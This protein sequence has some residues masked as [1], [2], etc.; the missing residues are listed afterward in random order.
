MEGKSLFQIGQTLYT[1]DEH[2]IKE[3]SIQEVTIRLNSDGMAVFYKGDGWA[4]YDEKYCFTTKDA[5]IRS[6]EQS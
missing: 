3:F 2:K 1:I 5:L 4:M 6:L